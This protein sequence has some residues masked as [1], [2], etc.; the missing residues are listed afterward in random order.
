MQW[1]WDDEKVEF[2]SDNQE[3]I[4]AVAN[5]SDEHEP[6]YQSCQS[7]LPKTAF[8]HSRGRDMGD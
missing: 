7:E 2:T 1:N 3:L 8:D 4:F 5:N 6:E